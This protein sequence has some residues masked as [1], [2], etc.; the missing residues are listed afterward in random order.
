MSDDIRKQYPP[1]GKSRETFEGNRFED[2]NLQDVHYQLRRERPEP[3]EGFQPMPLFIT[4]LVFLLAMWGGIELAKYTFHF[5][6][7]HFD[8]TKTAGAGEAAAAKPVDPLVLGK[9][10]FSQNCLACHQADGKGTPGVFPPLAESN[11]V[12]SEDP[13]RLVAIVLQGLAGEIVVNG[14]TY[15][16]AM[17]PF[18]RL[19]DA[20][21]AAVLT[22]IRSSPDFGN[23]ASPVDEALVAEVRAQ[24][25]SRAEQWTVADL[26][27]LYGPVKP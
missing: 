8:E 18:G 27:A 22:Y 21:I 26:E 7:Y 16:N 25:A 17:T 11:W 6:P 24:T 5:D 2:G 10:V 12:R 23:N 9:K 14:N 15:N 4:C 20:Q 13:H 19:K 1:D 3:T